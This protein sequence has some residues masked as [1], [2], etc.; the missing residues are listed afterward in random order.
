M[1]P[2]AGMGGVHFIGI[3]RYTGCFNP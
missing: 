2:R 1:M 3:L